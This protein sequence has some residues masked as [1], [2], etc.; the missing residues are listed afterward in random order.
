MSGFFARFVLKYIA[1]PQRRKEGLKIIMKVNND[2]LFERAPV[3]RAI[4]SLVIPTIISQIITVIYNMA[5]TFFI[6]QLGDPNQVAAA[7]L[8][9]PPF[10]MLTGFANLF[11]IGGASLI[12][13]SLGVG[14][15][16]RA[17]RVASFA[18][19]TA[20]ASALLYGLLFFALAPVIL[21]LLGTDELTYGFCYEYLLWCVTVGAVPT[22][23][24]ACLAHLVRSE[25]HAG[26]A[27][28]G[29]ALG[30]VL[31]ILLDPLFIFAF[32]LGIAGAAIATMVSNVAAVIYFVVLIYKN[33][34]DTVIVP[35]IKNYRPRGIA[36]EV[37]TVGFPSFVLLFMGT[38]S[39]IVLN[40]LVSGYSNE[41]IAGM[42]IAKKIDTLAFAIANGMS[43]GVL[44]LI[45]YNFA[46]KN[47]DRMKKAIKTSFVYNIAVA[48]VG[49]ILLFTLAVPVL[50]FFIDDAA[51]VEYGQHFLRTICVTCPA[52]SVTMM[53][54][55]IF[56]ATGRRTRPMILSFIR[57][58]GLDI[59]LVFFIN[60]KFGS[61]GIPFTTP[62]CDLIAVAVAVILF[63][64]YVKR[65]NL[66]AKD[67]PNAIDVKE[68]NG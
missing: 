4:I 14:D 25:G 37:V 15:R 3:W 2:E 39:N 62:I 59:P 43:Q 35:T 6:G 36:L 32:G 24:N 18:I 44:P 33:R 38:A 58:G 27:S 56:Q 1:R 7:T 51:T 46:A 16:E 12:S 20:A 48:T 34:K 68:K 11:G 42:G 61:Y 47:Y 65:I 5:D 13:R 9:M 54:I 53:I 29:M 49:A 67:S 52:I 50:R 31:N 64:P 30:G 17:K 55:A 63:I 45:G 26:Q 22:V 23:L 19:Y 21:P 41:C 40:K 60:A 66:S 10:V 28:V 8:A 57:K